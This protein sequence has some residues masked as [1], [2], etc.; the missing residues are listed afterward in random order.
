MAGLRL[1]NSF[2]IPGTV[3]TIPGM[4]GTECPS[5][6]GRSPLGSLVNCEMYW[7]FKASATS[8]GSM[9]LT[10][11]LRTVIYLCPDFFC[12]I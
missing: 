5:T 10:L 11:V 3:N 8:A 6:S 12:F 4:D 1:F 7:E 9:S 2:S